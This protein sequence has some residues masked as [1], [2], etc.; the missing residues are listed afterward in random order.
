MREILSSS[1]TLYFAPK[2]GILQQRKIIKFPL[3]TK[4]NIIIFKKIVNAL[5][6]QV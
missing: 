1:L 3:N 5:Y 2:L 6:F 4:F